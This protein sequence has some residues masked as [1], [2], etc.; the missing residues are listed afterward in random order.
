MR[1][2]PSRRT[3]KDCLH[4][5]PEEEKRKHKRK[6]LVQSPTSSVDVKCSGCDTLTTAFST[7]GSLV[8]WLLCQAVGGKARL[9][10]GCSSRQK[11]HFMHPESK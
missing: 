7:H 5:S 1:T 9:I 10:E 8:C 6:R 11:Q 3:T 2:C 4:L